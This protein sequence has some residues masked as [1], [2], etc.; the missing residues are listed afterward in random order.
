M[1]TA[2]I[3]AT[4]LEPNIMGTAAGLHVT[5]LNAWQFQNV[6]RLNELCQ[7]RKSP[8]Q[9]RPWPSAL[10]VLACTAFPAAA[11][12]AIPILPAVLLQFI[13]L[14][15]RASLT[16]KLVSC[17]ILAMELSMAIWSSCCPAASDHSVTVWRRSS[18]R[19]TPLPLPGPQAGHG[20]PL[21]QQTHAV[22]LAA[23]EDSPVPHSR[24]SGAAATARPAAAA[25]CAAPWL[26]HRLGWPAA[27]AGICMMLS[28]IV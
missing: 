16:I 22:Q 13:Q 9:A 21:R 26:V 20:C 18:G 19:M 8:S 11:F 24:Q 4:A 5:T 3:L 15:F 17:E 2:C 28:G 14:S 10:A 25:R 1:T 12:G 27:A 6:P 7:L 23:A